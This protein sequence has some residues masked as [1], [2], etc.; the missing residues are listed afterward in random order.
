MLLLFRLCIRH[1]GA[2]LKKQIRFAI[3]Q[4]ETMFEREQF[5]A[6]VGEKSG[7]SYASGLAMIESTYAVDIDAEY[8]KDKCAHLRSR[9]EA[10]KQNA[11]TYS[12]AIWYRI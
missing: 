3:I 1:P 5:I 12:T 11:K 7:S 6:Y 10:D 4:E 2:I 9:I 8:L